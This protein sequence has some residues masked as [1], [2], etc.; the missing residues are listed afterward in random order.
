MLVVVLDGFIVLHT[1]NLPAE[2][3]HAVNLHELCITCIVIDDM[4]LTLC[5]I[6]VCFCVVNIQRDL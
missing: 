1:S 2:E 3:V 4:K 5:M 6:R